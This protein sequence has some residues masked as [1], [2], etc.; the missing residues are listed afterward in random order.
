MPQIDRAI[1]RANNI[2]V[3]ALADVSPELNTEGLSRKL[4]EL[5]YQSLANDSISSIEVTA[6]NETATFN[7]AAD[8]LAAAHSMY[9]AGDKVNGLKMAIYAFN[10]PDCKSLFRGLLSLNE[11]AVKEV[12]ADVNKRVGNFSDIENIDPDNLVFGDEDSNDEDLAHEG[13]EDIISAP[14]IQEEQSLNSDLTNPGADAPDSNVAQ[15]DDAI[16]GV[17]PGDVS[18]MAQILEDAVSVKADAN[19][20]VDAVPGLE[21]GASTNLH[22]DPAT[23]PGLNLE[24]TDP[25]FQ[26]QYN[27]T[28]LD[29]NFVN[30]VENFSPNG[31]G[32][33][34]IDDTV[35]GD[36]SSPGNY[37]PGEQENLDQSEDDPLYNLIATIENPKIRSACYLLANKPGN[38][39]RRQLETFVRYYHNKKSA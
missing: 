20:T 23:D 18:V 8:A 30:E 34:G 24:N 13:V 2:L 17:P 33:G 6:S 37:P 39:S 5:I 1:K 38:K 16:E 9:L 12:T 4:K 11:E 28:P 22:D 36:P 25:N 26:N 14:T 10:S 15:E 29:V 27:V 21:D 7:F 31:S 32:D 19:D 3:E 35:F